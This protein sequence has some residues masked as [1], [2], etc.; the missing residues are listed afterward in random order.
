MHLEQ[1]DL[2]DAIAEAEEAETKKG[3]LFASLPDTEVGE[4]YRSHGHKACTLDAQKSFASSEMPSKYRVIIKVAKLG[5][6][7]YMG[8]DRE[9]DSYGAYSPLASDDL[10]IHRSCCADTVTEIALGYFRYT[11]LARDLNIEEKD[12]KAMLNACKVALQKMTKEG[13]EKV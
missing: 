4:E 3:W 13:Y 12:H 8:F 10:S 6:M 2:L 1:L 5:D 11:V 9:C 7:L